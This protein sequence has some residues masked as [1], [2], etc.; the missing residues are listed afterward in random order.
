MTMCPELSRMSRPWW[1]CLVVDNG[2]SGNL[3][4]GKKQTCSIGN[5]KGWYFSFHSESNMSKA[6]LNV[7]GGSD[8]ESS[9][10]EGVKLSEVEGELAASEVDGKSSEVDGKLGAEANSKSSAGVDGESSAEV[11]G[12]SSAE[13]GETGLGGCCLACFLVGRSC[14]EQSS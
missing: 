14:F 8:G 13:V 1:P 10:V 5:F 7:S 12:E 3:L 6:H 9:E 11:N 4:I 2:A